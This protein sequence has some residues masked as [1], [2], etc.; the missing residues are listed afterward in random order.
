[1]SADSQTPRER[2]YAAVLYADISGSTATMGTTIFCQDEVVNVLTLSAAFTQQSDGRQ[3]FVSSSV[4]LEKSGLVCIED[5]DCTLPEVCN[6][7][8]VCQELLSQLS[9]V[10]VPDTDGDGTHDD[11]DNCPLQPNPNQLDFDGDGCSATCTIEPVST[12]LF[13]GV[14]AGGTI[15]FTVSGV[16]LVVNTM[17]DETP[18]QVA[19]NV[20]AAINANSSLQSLGIAAIA[21]AGLVVTNG[22]ISNVTVNDAGL[23]MNWARRQCLPCA[24]RP[25]C[26]WL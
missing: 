9:V 26:S 17:L 23:T 16:V 21:N 10:G 13:G 1:M 7:A 5:S 19:A 25:F 15:N 11:L 18:T 2:R 12:W 24:T 22:V 4:V 20:A 14:A 3:I 8:G 6:E